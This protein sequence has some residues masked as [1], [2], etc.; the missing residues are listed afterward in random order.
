[1]SNLEKNTVGLA[2][3][4]TLQEDDLVIDVNALF[5]ALCK[6]WWLLMIVAILG[7]TLGYLTVRKPIVT[8]YSVKLTMCVTPKPVD[9]KEPTVADVNS[10]NKLL[11]TYVNLMENTQIR[12]AITTASN[13]GY[14]IKKVNDM[15]KSYFIEDTN[16]FI[17]TVTGDAEEAVQAIADAVVE[18]VPDALMEIFPVGEVKTVDN[19]GLI[20]D[21]K[22][23]NP[24]KNAIIGAVFLMV[25]AS[26][27]I[28]VL[29][30]IKNP[31]RNEK[32]LEKAFG[33]VS[34]GT[35][36]Q[37]KVSNRKSKYKWINK[38]KLH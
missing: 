20:T 1:M 26:G 13:T 33:M 38:F 2:N 19:T 29:E 25:F 12:E 36:P 14:E 30:L 32:D 7:A 11:P 10:A 6:K 17:V 34:L 8:S 37:F 4:H 31:I 28:C 21:V 35:I 24:I 15:L 23:K 22:K 27:I 5:Y 9:D 3:Q 18:V 16:I